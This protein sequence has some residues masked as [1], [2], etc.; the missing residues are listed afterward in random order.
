MLPVSDMLCKF[1]DL[2]A[3][4]RVP[5]RNANFSSRIHCMSIPVKACMTKSLLLFVRNCISGHAVSGYG[6]SAIYCLE[7]LCVRLG[8]GKIA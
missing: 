4:N 8:Y 1:G 2:A 6:P 7:A 3:G 5:S